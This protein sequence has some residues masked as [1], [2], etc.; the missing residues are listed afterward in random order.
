MYLG[1]VDG[2][3]EGALEEVLRNAAGFDGPVLVH[4]I[5][6]KGKGYLPAERHPSRFH[7]ADPFDV[8]TGLPLQNKEV[9]YSDIFSTVMVKMGER[10]ESVCAVTAA[11]MT[12]TGLQRFRN[13]YPDRFF[14]VGIAEEHAVTFAAGLAAQGLHPVC[15]IY[16]SFLQR[17]YDQI[18]HDVCLQD[19]HVVFAVDRAGVVG[20]DG[21]THQ[22]VFDIAFLSSI[23]NMTICAPK[24]KWELSD[25]IK[26]ALSYPHPIAVRYPRGAVCTDFEDSRQKVEIGKAEVLVR[27]EKVLFFA[28]GSMV[29]TAGEAMKILNEKGLQ[30]GL[31]NARFA[32]P[33]DRNLLLKAAE[34]YSCII[35]LE[36]GIVRGG[37]GR[38]V[39]ALLNEAGYS[40]KVL[41]M[42][43]PD[44][45]VVQG[46]PAAVYRKYGLDA[47]SIAE[48]AEEFF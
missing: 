10:D 13:K 35:T 21:P 33:L 14:D 27:G 7:G 29:K 31:V 41:N 39:L 22:G 32:K 15:A 5:T 44:D 12:G 26:A 1:P 6:K 28:L 17:A 34:N 11:M 19:L 45:F 40:G 38:E 48:Q 46:D 25:M 20:R 3:D 9:S 16:S 43:F 2:H 23:P 24:N 4:V 30:P 36:D 42:G 8:E 37:M 18:L 47:A